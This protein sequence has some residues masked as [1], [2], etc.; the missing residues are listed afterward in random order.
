MSNL[1]DLWSETQASLIGDDTGP[2]LTLRNTAGGP[3]LNVDRLV[4]ISGATMGL[5][6]ATDMVISNMT[7]SLLRVAQAIPAANATIIGT[8]FQGASRASGALFAFT[9]N[10]LVS[11]TSVLA[12]TGGVAGT[13]GLRVV[14]PD[15]TFGWIPVYPDGAVTAAAI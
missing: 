12:T 3:G 4:A 7:V 11:L 14:R 13:Y 15:G 9:A 6:S 2:A 1:V 8:S 10:A 5:L